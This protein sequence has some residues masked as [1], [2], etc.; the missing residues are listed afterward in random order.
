[1][2]G[3]HAPHVQGAEERGVEGQQEGVEGKERGQASLLSLVYLCQRRSLTDSFWTV[4][5][6]EG[7]EGSKWNQS[8]NEVESRWDC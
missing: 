1:M 3:G 8:G 7:L 2:E 6:S 5:K 4:F